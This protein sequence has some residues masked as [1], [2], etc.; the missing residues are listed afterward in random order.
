ML[1]LWL[2]PLLWTT[3]V[4][5]CEAQDGLK[6]IRI[7]AHSLEQPYLDSDLGSRH[8]DFGGNTVIR[9]DRYVRLTPERQSQ[10]GW[11]WSK[12]PLTATNFEITVQFKIHGN[13]HLFGDGMALWITETHNVQGPVYGSTDR[14]KGLGLFIDTYK[15]NRPSTVFPYVMVMMGDGHTP[16]DSTHDGKANELA[17]C[18][19]KGI[20]N[21]EHDTSLRLTYFQ[22]QFLKLELDYKGKG[23]WEPC[24]QVDASATDVK[25]PQTAYL[26]FSAETGELTEYHDV[27]SVETR[28]L[29][30]RQYQSH[31]TGSKYSKSEKEPVDARYDDVSRGSW[32]MSLLKAL[33]LLLVLAAAYVGYTVYRA[34]QRKSRF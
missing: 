25:I 2:G 30:D 15:N 8:W 5:R 3:F 16:Y 11:L 21:S 29:Y 22:D 27:I 19:A 4:R 26:G 28:N 31:S 7:E 34:N 1:F 17:G 12:S 33:L 10:R 24:F 13:N 9:T 14:F 20:R 18:S 32:W 23:E 6:S